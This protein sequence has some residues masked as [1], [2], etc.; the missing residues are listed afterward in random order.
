MSDRTRS[1][2]WFGPR[3]CH[4]GPKPLTCGSSESSLKQPAPTLG[5]HL[6]L[7]VQ[8]CLPA[9]PKC[10][11]LF[12]KYKHTSLCTIKD[13]SLQTHVTSS[14]LTAPPTMSQTTEIG[15]CRKNGPTC[16]NSCLPAF[17][18]QGPELCNSNSQP[19]CSEGLGMQNA[20]CLSDH[21]TETSTVTMPFY[22]FGWTQRL[23]AFDSAK[24]SS[25]KILKTL[26][27]WHMYM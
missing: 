3:A 17:P 26:P 19:P 5:P 8:H 27:T 21:P 11:V 7:Q 14:Q 9:I 22:F 1:W 16:D 18:M 6:V 25:Y 12:S 15:G 2:P 13:D 4:T 10:G 24:G 20:L 23:V